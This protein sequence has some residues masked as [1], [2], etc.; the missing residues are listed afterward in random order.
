MIERWWRYRRHAAD[1]RVEVACVAAAQHPFLLT[2]RELAIWTECPHC[3]GPAGH[4]P[5]DAA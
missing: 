4:L 1:G 2:L 5:A 3:T